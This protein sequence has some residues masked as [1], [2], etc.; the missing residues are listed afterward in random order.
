M[1]F[2]PE[3]AG[4]CSWRIVVAPDVKTIESPSGDQPIAEIA[5]SSARTTSDSRP[6]FRDRVPSSFPPALP[7]PRPDAVLG[8][9]CGAAVT[10]TRD[11]TNAT[12]DPSGEG[13][14]LVSACGVVH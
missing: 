8:D 2:E 5:L 11:R 6:S 1:I 7:R 4:V 13:T 9:A 3:Y 12:R 14:T 10:P